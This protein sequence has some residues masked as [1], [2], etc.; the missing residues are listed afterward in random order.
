M[1]LRWS[2]SRQTRGFGVHVSGS[3][4]SN[5]RQKKNTRDVV[6]VGSTVNGI[7]AN[8]EAASPRTIFVST[9][10]AWREG[11]AETAMKVRQLSKAVD[12]NKTIHV[13]SRV[14]LRRVF[15]HVQHIPDGSAR[16]WIVDEPLELENG[17]NFPVKVS[18]PL[19]RKVVMASS[20]AYIVHNGR[21]I[22]L[23]QTQSGMFNAGAAAGWFHSLSR[24]DWLEIHQ[25]LMRV[26][27]A[28]DSRFRWR[29]NAASLIRWAIAD[30]PER[31]QQ[32][33][34]WLEATEK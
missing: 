8:P 30:C 1:E 3:M 7:T 26:V 28:S 25:I 22:T 31:N 23:G 2:R 20:T 17:I 11:E 10:D 33:M 24:A 4:E 29:K 27:E 18:E 12:L 13:Q 34:D 16:I 32:W 21:E 19:Y 5:I 6:A 14:P 15:L 9:D